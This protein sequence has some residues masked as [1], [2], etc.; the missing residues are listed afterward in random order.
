MENSEENFTS[1][2]VNNALCLLII[3]IQKAFRLFK[4]IIH[5][6]GTAIAL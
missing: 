3:P 5:P 2:A 1:G 6:S 4:Q